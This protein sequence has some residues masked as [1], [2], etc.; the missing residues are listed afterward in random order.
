MTPLKT[1]RLAIVS[2]FFLMTSWITVFGADP[3]PAAAPDD[4]ALQLQGEYTTKDR[5]VHVIALG[6]GQFQCVIYEGGL[7]GAGWNRK[8]PRRVEGDADTV[9]DLTEDSE[10]VLRKSPTLGAKPPEGAVVLFDGSQESLKNHWKEGAKVSDDGLLQVGVTS[11]DSFLDFSLHLEFLLPFMP[12]QRGQGRANSGLYLQ[13][14][15]EVQILDSFGLEGKNNECGGFY[16]I[17]APDQNLCFPPLSW[18]TYDVDFRA[19]RFNEAGEKTETARVTVRHNGVVI[20]RDVQLPN[21]TP[22]GPSQDNADPGPVFLQNHG[23]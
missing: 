20:H 17:K 1:S 10:K 23:N 22:G 16:S 9:L 12:E 11:Q 3:K 19:A 13:G 15:Y 18:Q 6:G 8:E 7:P 4:Q 14:R 2:T 21:T 5:A